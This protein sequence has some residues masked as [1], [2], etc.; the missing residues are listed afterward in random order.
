MEY[1]IQQTSLNAVSP[2][3]I[4]SIEILKDGASLA[5]YGATA[6]NGVVLLH[7]KKGDPGKTRISFNFYAGRQELR[8]K[9]DLMNKDEFIDY[10]HLIRP[11]V[12]LTKRLGYDS[13]NS[14]DWQDVIFHKALTE[15]YNLSASGGNKRSDFYISS[16]YYRQEAIIK[17]L[18][19][20]RYS[21]RINYNRQFKDRIQLGN[22][23]SFSYLHFK[24]LK[25]GC[26]LN[27]FGNPILDALIM[28]PYKSKDD[29]TGTEISSQGVWNARTISNPYCHL[30]IERNRRK[31]YAFFNSLTADVRIIPNLH[32]VTWLGVE[33]YLQDNRSYTY[34]IPIV[35]NRIFS[36][37]TYHI[38]DLSFDWYNSLLYTPSF[39][40]YHKMDIRLDYEQ[41]GNI[42]KWI[43][44][45]CNSYDENMKYIPDA[46]G[47]GQ[48]SYEKLHSYTNFNY[49]AFIASIAYSYRDKLYINALLRR[50]D[51]G[52]YTIQQDF[53]KCYDYFPSFSL[54]WVFTRE[55]FSPGNKIF[56]YGKLRYGWGKAGNSPRINYTFFSRI[57]KEMDYVFALNSGSYITN[58]AICRRTNEQFYWESMRSHDLGIDLGFFQNRLFLSADYYHSEINE[59]KKYGIEK[60]KE[61][62]DILNQ[63]YMY[64]IYPPPLS[65]M[66]NKGFDL[67]L[68]YRHNGHTFKWSI[69]LNFN[70]F[71]NTV[72]DVN[73]SENLVWNTFDEMEPFFANLPGETAGSFYGYKI[74]GLFRAEDCDENG[75]AINQP[76]TFNTEGKKIYAQPG[77][78]A[79]DYKFADS[80]NDSVIDKNDRVILGN[81]FP[82]FAFGLSCQMQWKNFDVALVI[83][84]TYGNEIFNATKLYLYNPY[85][86]SNWA[87]DVTHSYRAPVYD[88]NDNLVDPGYTD[89]DLCRMDLNNINRN[90]RVSDFYIEDGSYVRLKNIQ[91]G[92]TIPP[93]ITKKIHIQRFRIFISSQNLLT[94]T[95]YSGIDPEIGGWG[96]DIG[97]YPQPRVYMV[98][99][100]V[101]F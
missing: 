77:A 14:T 25:E 45:I 98:G 17:N 82:D 18:Q 87:K 88:K 67:E 65:H 54:G 89:T 27:D 75:F 42:C 28:A 11:S 16:G 40:G 31:N 81:P 46:T 39:T 37:Y 19:L 96:I 13:I 85:G 101:E 59:G 84:G 70:H 8:K 34:M 79:G 53:R 21:F 36:E 56:Q 94:L 60:P 69:N 49:Y 58:S 86:Q 43:P 99:A 100:N 2:S 73:E 93:E 63:T 80:N 22:N 9:L 66:V 32:Y 10:Y 68:S 97:A 57:I 6:G 50:D 61:I 64:G 51:T 55:N 1:P 74:E 38:S 7:T 30:E 47:S 24:G 92:Y 72:L 26:Y 12:D 44:L 15:E 90:L 62:I 78:R 29:S 95:R 23:F 35:I 4:E 83:Q 5:K 20:D 91:L 76:Y 71:K 48:R 33:A 3:D 41:G 52:F